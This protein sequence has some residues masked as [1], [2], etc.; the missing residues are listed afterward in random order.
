MQ[1]KPTAAD[2]ARTFLAAVDQKERPAFE[3]W[4]NLGTT[5][6]SGYQ[7]SVDRISSFELP[8][9]QVCRHWAIAVNRHDL[10]IE[11]VP[12]LR[13]DDLSLVAGCLA[14]NS[15]ASAHFVERYGAGIEAALR[16]RRFDNSLVEETKQELLRQFFIGRENREASLL[17][18]SGKGSL[19]GWVRTSAVR[20]AI[21]Y[22]RKASRYVA[23]EPD[24][25]AAFEAPTGDVELDL[26]KAQYHDEFRA[27]MNEAL[28]MLSAED[29]VLLRHFYIDDM[30]SH[31]LAEMLGTHRATASR[32]IVRIRTEIEENARQYLKNT[33]GMTGSEFDSLARLVQ[34]QI[35]LSLARLLEE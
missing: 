13:F 10:S 14:G 25:C 21:D 18:Y 12:D 11:D 29:R 19:L 24:I 17:Q 4:A 3:R 5:L 27:A 31:Q 33:L 16:K 23:V 7:A 28:A 22:S 1:D 8:W 20:A 2:L 34:S 30:S 26:L 6:F 32:R 9:E 35:H 15:R